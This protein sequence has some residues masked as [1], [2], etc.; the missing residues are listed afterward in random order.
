MCAVSEGENCL[1][2]RRSR[3]SATHQVFVCGDKSVLETSPRVKK[4]SRRLRLESWTWGG[5]GQ[6]TF[7]AQTEGAAGGFHDAEEEELILPSEPSEQQQNED[8]A[9]I[10]PLFPAAV[11][12]LVLVVKLQ[13]ML[14]AP[15]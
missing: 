5:L 11:S 15:C 14:V 9:F 2:R 4:K 13:Q 7:R 8:A 12:E 6:R 1:P 10:Q 3:S